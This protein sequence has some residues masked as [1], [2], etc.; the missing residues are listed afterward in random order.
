MLK[1][2]HI[3]ELITNLSKAMPELIAGLV[4]DIDGLIIAKQSV[5]TFDE[6]LIAAIMTIIKQNLDK[7]KHYTETALGSGSFNTDKFQLFYVEVSKTPPMIFVLVIDPYANLEKYIPYSY[8]IAERISLILHD[9]DPSLKIPKLSEEGDLLFEFNS[10]SDKNNNHINKIILIGSQKVGKSTLAEMY[11]NGKFEE[12]YK[13]TV[14]INLIEKKLQITKN[15]QM[16]NIIFDLS[17]L[18][19]FANIRRHYYSDAKAVLILFDYNEAQTLQNV[20]EWLEEANH[21][22]KDKSIPYILIGNKIDLVND[23]EKIRNEAKKIANHYNCA[24]FETSALT[25]EGIDEVFT[26]LISH[27]CN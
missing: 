7:I 5:K 15:V 9:R 25:G 27:F 13:P 26:Y 3:N 1:T 2:A 24:F 4:V 14:G 18:K 20:T 10:G 11:T 23:R 17:G 22:I 16:N 19:S 8:I 21:F 12:I 6:E